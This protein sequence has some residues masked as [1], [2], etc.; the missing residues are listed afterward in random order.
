VTK[1]SNANSRPTEVIK[2]TTKVVAEVCFS[3]DEEFNADPVP[4]PS[5]WPGWA[6]R[7]C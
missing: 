5:L 3:G 7:S 2:T 1:K 6:T 4:P